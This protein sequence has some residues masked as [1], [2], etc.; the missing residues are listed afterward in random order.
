[1]DIK[2]QYIDDNIIRRWKNIIYTYNTVQYFSIRIRVI[3]IDYVTYTLHGAGILI[4]F[5][6]AASIQ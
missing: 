4:R 2:S 6:S 1:M 5:M 3:S